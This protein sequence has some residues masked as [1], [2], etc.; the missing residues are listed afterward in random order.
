MRGVLA[1]ARCAKARS[2]APHALHMPSHIFSTV[3]MWQDVIQSDRAA[4][5]MTMSYTARINQQAAANQAA[6]P[7]R[8]HSLDFLTNAHLQLV[9][10]R[11]AKQIVDVRNSIAEY[12]ASFRYSGH[13][14]F[15]AIPVRYALERGAWA[16]AAALQVPKTP[17]AQAEAIS[18]FGRGIGAAR[19][20][21]IAAAK[22][23]AE[24]LRAARAPTRAS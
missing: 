17:F 8:Y 5:G 11:E 3:G 22:D 16:E 6:N 15:A 18:W 21:D 13:T 20:G 14:A 12:P 2:L 1:A 9:Q 24:Q 7:A 23:A 19:S 4:D 10:D